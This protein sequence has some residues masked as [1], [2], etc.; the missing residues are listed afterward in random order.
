ML[1]T[2]A[3]IRRQDSASTEEGQISAEVCSSI[4]VS[5]KLAALED[6]V[7]QNNLML[8]SILNHL[9]AEEDEEDLLLQP[10]T[11]QEELDPFF[12]KFKSPSFRK[13]M[14]RL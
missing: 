9:M 3:P 8:R 11:A 2:S 13:K 6:V 5:A 7:M 10:F 1:P 12:Q 14:V 4:S